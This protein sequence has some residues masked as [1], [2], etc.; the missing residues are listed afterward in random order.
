M[1]RGRKER[2]ERVEEAVLI[3]V[4][5]TSTVSWVMKCRGGKGNELSG[6][7]VGAMMRM[8]GVLEVEGGFGFQ[9]KH[10]KGKEN[11]LADGITRWPEG[12]VYDNLMRESPGSPW[13]VQDIGEEARRRFM[14]ILREATHLEELRLRLAGVMRE[15]GGC[16]V[17]GERR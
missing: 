7:R 4:D 12:E 2:P 8:M 13:Q 16:G 1:V 11:V 9:A 17:H 5:N 6:E 3:R 10:V 15:I 14:E